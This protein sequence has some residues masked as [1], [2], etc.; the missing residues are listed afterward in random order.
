MKRA[1]GLLILIIFIM[2]GCVPAP[3][4][5][6]IDGVEKAINQSEEAVQ[7]LKNEKNVATV[8]SAL[9]DEINTTIQGENTSLLIAANVTPP[10]VD[11]IY[12]AILQPLTYDEKKLV[13][14]CFGKQEIGRASC[15]ERV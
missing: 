12:T 9:P 1:L 11:T 7:D 4:K 15:R 10:E 8:L 14:F 3:E 13:D 5:I 6:T 2:A